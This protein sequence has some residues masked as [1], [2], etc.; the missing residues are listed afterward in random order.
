[1]RPRRARLGL[2]ILEDR[3]VPSSGATALPLPAIG[4]SVSSNTYSPTDILVEYRA[5][6]PQVDLPGTSIGQQLGLVKNL[7]EINL[8]NGV[9]VTQALAAYSASGNVASAEPDYL[10]SASAIPNDPSFNQQ[11]ALRN[12]GQNGGTAGADIGAVQAW[13]A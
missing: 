10:L 11:W 8:S 4:V 1:L 6:Q 7:Y 5:N 9:S 2:E 12:T 13:N 3:T